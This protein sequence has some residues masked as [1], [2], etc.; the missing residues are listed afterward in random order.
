MEYLELHSQMKSYG[1][2]PDSGGLLDQDSFIMRMMD[3]IESE[4]IKIKAESSKDV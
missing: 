2:L 3:V 4:Y 1:S